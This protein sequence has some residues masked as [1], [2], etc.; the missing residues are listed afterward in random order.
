MQW[1]FYLIAIPAAAFMGHVALELVG[2]PLRTAFRLR[3]KALERMLSFRGISL[4]KPRELAISSREIREYDQA[5]RNVREAQ[6]TFSDLG[7][8]LLALGESEPTIR[9][10]MALFG[11]DIALA[12]HELIN[13]SEVYATAK[14]DSDELR[15]AIEKALHA[16]ST[17]LAVSGRLSDNGLIKIRLEPMYLRDAVYPRKRK[18]PLRQQR[19]V[20]RRVPPG[21]KPSSLAA[22][23]ARADQF[24]TPAA[25]AFKIAR[26]QFS[27]RGDRFAGEG[28]LRNDLRPAL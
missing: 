6:R 26:A 12:G 8:Q 28:Q 19:M 16:T 20:S 3:R 21:A 4:P 9:I 18:R 11:L 5:V 13:L 17:A 25:N 10:L 15:H 2:R 14:T 27:G 7:A 1:Y 23:N 24:T 22:A